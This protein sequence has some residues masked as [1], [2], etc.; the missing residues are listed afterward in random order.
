[1]QI[2]N[3]T[4]IM[5]PACLVFYF[6]NYLLTFVLTVDVIG[7]VLCFVPVVF[8]SWRRTSNLIGLSCFILW[9]LPFSAAAILWSGV[10]SRLRGLV[11]AAFLGPSSFLLRGLPFWTAA[12]LPGVGPFTRSCGGVVLDDWWP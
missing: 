1:M 9:T 5:G 3:R 7:R 6:F 2:I 8:H 10:F 11:V 12:I 4:K